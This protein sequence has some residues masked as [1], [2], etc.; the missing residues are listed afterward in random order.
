MNGFQRAAGCLV[1]CCKAP[2]RSKRRLATQ[3]GD[4][5]AEAAERLLA[6][7][8]EDLADWPGEAV[9]APASDDDAD[10]LR[11]QSAERFETVVQ[12]GNSLG[13]RIN[14]VDTVLRSSGHERLIYIGADCPA[15]DSDY[16]A[17]ADRALTD[18]DAVIGPATD[19]GVV[20]M[21]A[22]R[23]WPQLDDLAWSTNELRKELCTRLRGHD[24]S[25]ARLKT[26]SDVDTVEDLAIACD[27][28]ADDGRK[29]R[30]ALTNWLSSSDE[31]PEAIS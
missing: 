17:S 3:L 14:H 8:L 11:S 25:I 30:R 6:C 18:N 9:V 23:P 2:L 21:G 29:A 24:W 1:L 7:A 4:R 13:A 22:R 26:L 20:L 28:L 10:W 5:A 15:L 27:T 12:H 31:L 16:L 19:G